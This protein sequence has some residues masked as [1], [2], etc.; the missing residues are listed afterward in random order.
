LDKRRDVMS[1][2]NVRRLTAAVVLAALLGLAAPAAAAPPPWSLAPGTHGPGWLDQA[3]AWIASLWMGERAQEQ[4]PREK[5][6][7]AYSGMGSNRG[8]AATPETDLTS[9]ADPNG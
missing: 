3:I 7:A 8:Q 9:T 4:A 1:K 6:G 2:L 5:G